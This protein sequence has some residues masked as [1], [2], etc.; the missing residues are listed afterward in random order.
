M[1]ATTAGETAGT[2]RPPLLPEQR[3]DDAA[4]VTVVEYSTFE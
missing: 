2:Q 4:G 3:N 1:R